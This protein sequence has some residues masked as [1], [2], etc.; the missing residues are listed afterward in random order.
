MYRF[1]R[2]RLAGLGAL[3]CMLLL[4]PAAAQARAHPSPNGRHNIAITVSDNPVVAGDQLVIFGR[5]KGPNNG[6]RVVTLWHRINPR[7]RFTP[8]QRTT[9]DSQGFYAFFRQRG[10]VNTNRNWY[11]KSLGAPTVRNTS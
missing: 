4:L 3:I 9:T 6:H 7:P 11:V 10:V 1:S 5:L 2:L 8:V